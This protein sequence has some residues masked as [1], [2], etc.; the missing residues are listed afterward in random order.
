MTSPSRSRLEPTV[1]D[2]YI[3]NRNTVPW[4]VLALTRSSDTSRPHS[5]ETVHGKIDSGEDP[6]SA[7]RREV[8]EET[9]L[10]VDTL[11]SVTV[12]TFYLHSTGL[13]DVAMAFCAF[14]EGNESI[15][16]GP[17]HSEYCWVSID[18]V[19]DHFTWPR[20]V[21]ITR[22]IKHL[23]SDKWIDTVKDVLKT[24]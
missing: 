10:E 12:H 6:E 2:V 5:V 3:V 4:Q 13:I 16:L 18:E 15:T 11:Y 23:L 17:E 24:F 1:V 9:G 20:A 19:G 22:E 7:A 21:E 8:F 14:V